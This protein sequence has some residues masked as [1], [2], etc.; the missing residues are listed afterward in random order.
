MFTAESHAPEFS[1]EKDLVEKS[2]KK[3]G[4]EKKWIFLWFVAPFFY[5]SGFCG[6][7]FFLSCTSFLDLNL[8]AYQSVRKKRYKKRDLQTLFVF[9]EDSTHEHVQRKKARGRG[10]ETRE[11]ARFNSTV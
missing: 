6:S 10:G 4:F 3:S 8:I 7:C 5:L 9:V 11:K 1:G 2:V